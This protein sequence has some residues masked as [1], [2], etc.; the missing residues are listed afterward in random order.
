MRHIAEATPIR[1][2]VQFGH[3]IIN[4]ITGVAENYPY[5][6]RASEFQIN[7]I[8]A[9]AEL[10]QQQIS[11]QYQNMAYLM[12]LESMNKNESLTKEKSFWNRAKEFFGITN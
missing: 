7:C 5:P 3:L 2:K 10:R 9:E 4:P 1:I 6:D 8:K 12:M 11:Y